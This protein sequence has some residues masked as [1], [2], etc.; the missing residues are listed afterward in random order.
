LSDE[1][2]FPDGTIRPIIEIDERWD[3]QGKQFVVVSLGAG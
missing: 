3:E 2:E 1:I